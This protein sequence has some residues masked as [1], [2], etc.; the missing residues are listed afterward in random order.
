MAP[1]TRSVG[2]ISG[3]TRV[4]ASLLAGF[5]AGG[6]G[7]VGSTLLVST[8][9]SDWRH[10]RARRDPST[11]RS[12]TDGSATARPGEPRKVLGAASLPG[13]SARGGPPG[14]RSGPG[15]DER[16]PPAPPDPP[17]QRRCDA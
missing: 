1:G 3:H 17:A 14:D 12:A 7:K 9:P 4:D 13:R 8:E 6:A 16:A 10:G 11:G 15:P 2:R 5:V